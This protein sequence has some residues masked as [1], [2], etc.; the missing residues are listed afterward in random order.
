VGPDEN[1]L[2]FIFEV[3]NG[4]IKSMHEYLDTLASARACGDLPYPDE[5]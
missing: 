4:K 2:I 1:D 3:K 5:A